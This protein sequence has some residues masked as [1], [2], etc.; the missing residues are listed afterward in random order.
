[1]NMKEGN[2]AKSKMFRDK[3]HDFLKND[4]LCFQLLS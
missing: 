2:S 3:I 1:M 4:G